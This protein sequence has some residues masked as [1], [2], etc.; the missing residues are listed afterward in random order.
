MKIDYE[1]L[2]I[3][4]ILAADEGW[5][6]EYKKYLVKGQGEDFKYPVA[7]HAAIV[8]PDFDKNEET[9]DI[10][11]F[12]NNTVITRGDKELSKKYSQGIQYRINEKTK[13][14]EV[15]W[16]YGKERG[17]ELHSN[18]ISSSRYMPNTGNRLVDFGF[19]DGGKRSHIVE[20]DDSYPANVVFEAVLTSKNKGSWIYRAERFTLYPEQ[21]NFS[22]ANEQ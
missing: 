12:D 16:A 22:I 21:W 6:E 19:V 2:E 9:I 5:P 14:A 17:E 10:M 8:L 13:E 18:I 20:T 7:Q 11:L 4:W 3:K 1:T 15:I